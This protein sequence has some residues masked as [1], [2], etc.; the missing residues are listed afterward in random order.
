MQPQQEY[1]HLMYYQWRISGNAI[2]VRK[3]Y[4][5]PCTCHFHQKI[6]F[7]STDTYAPMFWSQANIPP[8]HQC[9][10]TWSCIATWNIWSLQ[11]SHISQ[12]FFSMLQH[13]QQVFGHNVWWN[14]SSGNFRITVQHMS[15]GKQTVL[16][17]KQ[18]LDT[19][20]HCLHTSRHH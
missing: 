5:Q 20:R 3:H 8:V 2:T 6:H 17:S 1:F 13:K 12:K 11:L 4:L 18:W 15:T 9:T 19:L 14:Q 16:Q 7:I 10:H